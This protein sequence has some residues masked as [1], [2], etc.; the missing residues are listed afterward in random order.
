MYPEKKSVNFAFT[1]IRIKNALVY[2][3]INIYSFAAE[4]PLLKGRQT[5]IHESLQPQR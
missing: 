2:V 5:M 4:M 3:S 1:I